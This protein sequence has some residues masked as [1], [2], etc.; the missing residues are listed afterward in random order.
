MLLDV[1]DLAPSESVNGVE[2]DIETVVV[3]LVKGHAGFGFTITESPYGQQ[4][5]TIVDK[6]RC[7]ELQSGDILIEING[8]SVRKSSHADLVDVFR[9]FRINERVT[10]VCNRYKAGTVT[11]EPVYS[12]GLQRTR[13]ATLQ[14]TF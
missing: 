5:N 12:S 14:S 4:V 6:E 8:K 9:Q 2:T 13:F 11:N 1:S 3:Q 7:R 10:L